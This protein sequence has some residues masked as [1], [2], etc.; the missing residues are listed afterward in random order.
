MISGPVGFSSKDQQMWLDLILEASGVL[1]SAKKI[2]EEL[3]ATSSLTN[4]TSSEFILPKQFN[5]TKYEKEIRT[6]DGTPLFFTKENITLIYL[7]LYSK[8]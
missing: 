5:T 4:S 2:E 1:E 3:N 8:F 7:N 6:K